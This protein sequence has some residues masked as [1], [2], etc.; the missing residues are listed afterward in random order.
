[1]EKADGPC[2]SDREFYIQHKPLV[3]ATVEPT[4][5]RTVY[6]APARASYG[7][8]SL[9]DSLHAGPPFSKQTLERSIQ[10]VF[11]PLGCFW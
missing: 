6:D 9:N 3:R 2:L 1:M 5:L 10:R 4:K 11:Q 8:P 7:A